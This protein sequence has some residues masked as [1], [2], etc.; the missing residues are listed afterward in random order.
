MANTPR[1]QEQQAVPLRDYSREHTRTGRI[2]T[3]VITT[4]AVLVMLLVFI[5]QN[6]QSVHISFFTASGSLP[7]A[8]AMLVAAV[9]GA[10]IVALAGSLRILQLRRRARR[11]IKEAGQRKARPIEHS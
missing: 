4:I 10:V 8:V 11:S 1:A 7:L 5:V 9:A 3:L 6:T 2:W